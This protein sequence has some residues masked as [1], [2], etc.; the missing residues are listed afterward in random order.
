[1]RSLERDGFAKT[2]LAH[3]P[4]ERSLAGSRESSKQFF[5]RLPILP[6]GIQLSPILPLSAKCDLPLFSAVDHQLRIFPCRWHSKW[7]SARA[8][9]QGALQRHSPRGFGFRS[10]TD[11]D[12]LSDGRDG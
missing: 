10:F 5:D 1:M 3:N 6:V 7:H 11:Q 8:V 12:E 4:R 9:R 2:K